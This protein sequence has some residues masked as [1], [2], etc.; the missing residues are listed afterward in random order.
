VFF[1]G[2][3]EPK[4]VL[5]NSSLKRPERGVALDVSCR[6]TNTSPASV[7]ANPVI[8]IVFGE[9]S[10]STFAT[11][12]LSAAKLNSTHSPLPPLYRPTFCELHRKLI[13][14]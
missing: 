3:H 7:I 10:G 1:I 14:P 6:L 9:G 12:S 4:P 13:S 5:S 11:L 2:T 8:R